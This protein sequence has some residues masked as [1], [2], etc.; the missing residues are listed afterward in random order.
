[1]DNYAELS[2]M[3]S[4]G[5]P[6]IFFN[7]LF[8]LLR[9]HF[10]KIVFSNSNYNDLAFNNNWTTFFFCVV[11]SFLINKSEEKQTNYRF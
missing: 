8:Y 4:C 6:N 11:C 2:S 10:D 3:T 1:M 9:L 5:Y 7:N